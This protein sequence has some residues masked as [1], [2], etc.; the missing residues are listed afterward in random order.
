MLNQWPPPG[1]GSACRAQNVQVVRSPE[2][3][4][5]F[6]HRGGLFLEDD[7]DHVSAILAN[8]RSAAQP[9]RA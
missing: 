2:D 7:T 4:G 3:H 1:H 9:W 8:H 5:S 6:V